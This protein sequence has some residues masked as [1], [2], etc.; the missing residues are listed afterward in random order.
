MLE[1][2]INPLYCRSS[3]QWVS[4]DARVFFTTPSF[5]GGFPPY[6]FNPISSLYS[7]CRNGAID[8]RHMS[9]PAI[10]QSC[11]LSPGPLCWPPGWPRGSRPAASNQAGCRTARK[12]REN[13]SEKINMKRMR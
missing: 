1:N 12:K 2:I 6:S 5:I 7:A 3:G 10:N 8:T 13:T 4:A 9:H 11:R